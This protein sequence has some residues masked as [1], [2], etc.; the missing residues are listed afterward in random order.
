MPST[1]RTLILASLLAAGIQ[2]IPQRADACSC[3]APPPP[4]EAAAAAAAVF[5]G[6]VESVS[7]GD[8]ANPRK[9]VLHVVRSFKGDLTKER[10][11]LTTAAHGAACGYGFEAG[12][13]YLVYANEH[14]GALQ[15]NLCSR[16]R[17]ISEADE[18]VQALGMGATPVDPTG[19]GATPEPDK[20]DKPARGGCAGCGVGTVGS[21][22]WSATAALGLVLGLIARRRRR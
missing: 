4:K 1:P 20:K 15:T 21:D 5:E 11:E 12:K 6:R 16:T 19:P 17:P 8:P 3:A 9:V 13:S 2:L 7:A 18:D 22:A 14:Q 10:I